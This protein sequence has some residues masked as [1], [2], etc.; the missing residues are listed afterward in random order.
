MQSETTLSS[1]YHVNKLLGGVQ[2]CVFFCIFKV[3][4]LTTY[5]DLVERLCR[6]TRRVEY[7]NR[8]KPPTTVIK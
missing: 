7:F 2:Q 5:Y 8:R 4:A 6:H 1:S 3:C